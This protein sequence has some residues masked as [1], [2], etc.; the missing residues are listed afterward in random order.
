M[1]SSWVWLLHVMRYRCTSLHPIQDRLGSSRYGLR[2]FSSSTLM[3]TMLMHEEDVRGDRAYVALLFGE[4][5]EYFLCTLTLG[6]R[7][8]RLDRDTP[9]ILMLGCGSWPA[10]TGYTGKRRQCLDRLWEVVEVDLVKQ[11]LVD[12]SNRHSYVFTKLHAL[13]LPYRR[14]LFLDLDVLPRRSLKSLF[15]VPAPAALYHGG[16]DRTCLQ[17]GQ[18][19][20]LEAFSSWTGCI[21]AGL[22]RLDPCRTRVLRAEQ[23]ASLL[24]DVHKMEPS[25]ASNLPEQYFLAEKLSG[26]RHLDVA[27]NAEVYPEIWPGVGKTVKASDW[28]NLGSNPAELRKNVHMWHF[29]GTWLQ[30]W[31]FLIFEPAQAFD[32]LLGNH[33]STDESGMA[34]T[35]VQEWLQ[36]FRQLA[37][38]DVQFYQQ[39]AR[40]L[41]QKA[42]AWYSTKTT[43]CARGLHLI[44]KRV[45]YCPECDVTECPLSRAWKKQRNN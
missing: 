12:R 22:I 28:H 38:E 33:S 21:N 37:Q 43:K 25:D 34:A 26:W 31:W 19:I 24:A 23:V 30:P 39:E 15:E 13:S 10:R 32:F 17:H 9:R 29:S 1:R 16:Y 45:D 4:A 20:P 14:V 6:E 11:T 41:M 44:E 7:L 35:A 5:T 3:A 18:Q 36:A 27:W 8:R 40:P 2:R 42:D